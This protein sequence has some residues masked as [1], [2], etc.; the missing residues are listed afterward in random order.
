[1]KITHLDSLPG[2]DPRNQADGTFSDDTFLAPVARSPHGPAVRLRSSPPDEPPRV[3]GLGRAQETT[4][5][6][7]HCPIQRGR[8][9]WLRVLL[10]QTIH[11]QPP[12]LSSSEVLHIQ[13][14]LGHGRQWLSMLGSEGCT[15]SERHLSE[16]QESG[17][18]VHYARDIRNFK[19]LSLKSH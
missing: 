7:A 6:C 15:Y 17:I 4:P 19:D 16:V 8:P 2:R 5:S 13:G 1:M 3:S 10:F 12:R 18:Y 9:L 14:L 11:H